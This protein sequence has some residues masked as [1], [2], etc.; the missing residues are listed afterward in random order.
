MTVI[1]VLV[2]GAVTIIPC[3]VQSAPSLVHPPLLSSQDTPD[4]VTSDRAITEHS[5]SPKRRK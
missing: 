1:D 4:S 5:S 3:N 2:G